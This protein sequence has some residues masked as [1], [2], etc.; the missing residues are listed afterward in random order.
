V[1][2][3]A[4]VAALIAAP[5]AA[6]LVRVVS[7]PGA[8]LAHL[9][10]TILPQVLADT[11]L[12]TLL[13]GFGSSLIGV[14][15]AWLVAV[16]RFP[17]SRS[18]E[19]LL[20]LPLAMPAYII[21]YAYTDLFEVAGPVQGWLRASFGWRAG[22]Y[23][24][25]EVRSLPGAATMLFLVLYPYVYVLAR[26]AFIEQSPNLVNAARALGAGPGALFVKVCLPLARPAIAAGAGLAMMEAIADYGVAHYF[27][28]QT[29]TPIIYRTWF[30]MGD[31]AAA[32]QLAGLLILS[33]LLLLLFERAMRGKR[34]FHQG[35]KPQAAPAR[36]PLAGWRGWAATAAC[37]L[38]VLLGFALPTAHLLALHLGSGQSVLDPA[39][40]ERAARSF[41]LAGAGA[42]LTV[43][44]AAALTLTV[45]GAPDGP[46]RPL[47]RVATLGYAMPGAVVALGILGVAG[48]IDAGLIAGVRAITGAE[49]G[50]VLG[51][52]IAAVMF[53]YLVRFLAIGVGGIEAGLARIHGR[54]EDAARTLGAPRRRV[55]R[56]I[57]APLLWRSTL[58][59]AVVVFADILKELPATIVLRP[60]NFETLAVRTHQLASDER[61]AEAAGGALIIVAIGLVPVWVI[62]AMTRER[63][64]RPPPAAGERFGAFP[65]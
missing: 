39:V 49:I 64:R 61:L 25:P 28:L 63:T 36:K 7:P 33:V 27:A 60:F 10:S 15:T 6:V 40:A 22:E 23:W 21:A 35:A 31:L 65:G 1:L 2:I 3:A 57:L 8:T 37:A 46:V 29:I 30:G 43:A 38:P 17:G 14:A 51:G 55:G 62:F 59:T 4:A 26:S 18:L 11:A 32:T 9:W 53:A 41:V 20:L 34:A 58:T 45:R 47:L 5:L 12:L 54:I 56:T 44:V 13:V 48:A 24:F 42:L 16:Y 50:L 52:S 19:W